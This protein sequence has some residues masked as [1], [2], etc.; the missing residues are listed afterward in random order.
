MSNTLLRSC[1][2]R[3]RRVRRSRSRSRR[4]RR[5][6]WLL[7]LLVSWRY[8]IWSRL[9]GHGIDPQA[10]GLSCCH[11]HCLCHCRRLSSVVWAN[12]AHDIIHFSFRFHSLSSWPSVFGAPSS[13]VSSSVRPSVLSP[14]S[15]SMRVVRS[16]FIIRNIFRAHNKWKQAVSMARTWCVCVRASACT[17]TFKLLLLLL[18]FLLL[19]LLLFLLLTGLVC[20]LECRAFP[21]RLTPVPRRARQTRHFLGAPCRE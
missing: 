19:V 4:R 5:R 15:P 17:C 11:C 13:S 6:R 12:N 21:V 7:R 18:L 14:C 9:L 1:R 20:R 8:R 16:N 10:T 3:R 2:H